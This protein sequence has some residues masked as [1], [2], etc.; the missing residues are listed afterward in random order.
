MKISKLLATNKTVFKAREIGNLLG[1]ENKNYLKIVLSR[2][3]KS[4][5]LKKIGNGFYSLRKDF[6]FYELA[7]KLKTP[8]YV[9][10]ETVLQK[11]GVIF[12]DYSG[13]IFSV[14]NNTVEKKVGEIS[15]RY[16]KIKDEVLSNMKGIKRKDNFLIASKERAL[17]DKLYLSPGFYFDNL[18]GINW[19]KALEIANIYDNKRL[20]NCLKSQRKISE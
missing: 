5:D 14:S 4:G 9:S 18:R 1:V 7:N 17:C 3:R 2:A 12:Q 20:R 15:Y 11:E 6:D 16:F 10:L 8:S 13:S 19:G